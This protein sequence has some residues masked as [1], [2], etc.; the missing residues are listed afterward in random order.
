[1]LIFDYL[2]RNANLY[3]NNTA[4]VEII[5]NSINNKN[6]Y[7]K[8]LSWAEVCD[9]SDK[10][11]GY[12]MAQGIH[13][14]D[15]VGILLKNCIEW[16]P[17]YFG[18]LAAG[19]VVVPLN[20]HLFMKE[21]IY[22]IRVADIK[23]L[24][25][26]TEL[27]KDLDRIHEEF[28]ELHFLTV[29]EPKS[30]FDFAESY[31]EVLK[32]KIKRPTRINICE[33]DDAAI[34]FTTGTTGVP[35]A[36]L[37]SHGNLVA[38][39]ITEQM[40]HKQTQSDVFLCI[41]PL[42]HTGSKM[43]WFGSLIVGGKGVLLHDT[44]P[45]GILDTIQRERI[46]NAWLLLPW[47]QDILCAIEDHQICLK[48]FDLKD[49]KLMH[50]GAQPIPHTIIKRW[51]HYFPWQD[52][53]VSYGLTEATGPGVAHLGNENLGRVDTIGKEG[54]SWGIRIL[55]SSG[56]TVQPGEIG[57]LAVC[58]PGVMKGYLKNDDEDVFMGNWL[59]TGDLGYKDQE[60]FIYLTGRKKDIIIVGGENVSVIKIENYL[61]RCEKIKDVAIIGIPYKKYGEA[62]LAIVEAKKEVVLSE[63]EVSD[64]C[65]QLPRHQRP[66]MIIFDKV[67]RNELGKINKK[68][69]REKYLKLHYDKERKTL[70]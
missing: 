45:F 50:M 40:H 3:Q 67:L 5:L 55:D 18:I 66:V 37:L 70:K 21:L 14:G 44:T 52:M 49:W 16:L 36:V 62:I 15:R 64:Y 43:H 30:D 7:S 23:M 22:C 9:I 27:I 48:E 13:K 10:I 20:Y 35:K 41:P 54:Y 61:C 26:K 63:K 46:T 39:A 25:C 51:L 19:A 68:A 12:L 17:I 38:S 33:V 60:G 31:E 4:L 8:K 1:M 28:P 32:S 65:R 56:Q 34:Y 69:L 24:V 53:D 2:Y 11:S 42:Y 57:E 59:L 6:E 47:V 58:G 29:R